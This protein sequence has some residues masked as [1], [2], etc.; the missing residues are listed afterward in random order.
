M[1]Q[2]LWL[3]ILLVGGLAVGVYI[4]WFGRGAGFGAVTPWDDEEEMARKG[5]YFRR[6][7]VE[8]K[9]SS[10]FPRQDPSEILRLLDGAPPPFGAHERM[11]LD[12]LKL[13][14]GDVAR[15]RH[16]IE[17]CG[18]A[19]GAVEV[20]NKAEYPWSSRFDSSGPAPKWIVERDTRRYLKWL[21]RR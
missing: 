11:Q 1:S 15:L 9:V 18:S 3:V 20:V 5:P 19:S 10:L 2:A 8:A 21:K 12:I 6:E 13:S 7:V 4:I 16:Y 14:G 17:L